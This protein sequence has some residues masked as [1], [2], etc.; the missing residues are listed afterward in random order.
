MSVRPL[1]ILSVIIVALLLSAVLSCS[2]RQEQVRQTLTVADSL[3]MT[4]PQAALDALMSIDS[5]DAAGLPRADKAFYTLL[6][7]EA[8]YK[9]WLPVAGNTAIAEAVDYYHR[10]EPEDRLARALVMQGAVLYERGD[11]EGA[12]LAYKEAEPILE[13]SGDLEQL[14]LLHTKIASLYQNN[15]FNTDEA[16]VRYRKAL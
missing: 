9:C 12:M 13:H 6:R 2:G 5:S 1:H 16:I 8:E 3:M 10:R 14:G 7:T 15:I 11:T 4:Q